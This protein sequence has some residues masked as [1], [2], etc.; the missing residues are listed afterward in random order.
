MTVVELK[1][2]V[3]SILD[4][5]ESDGKC[6]DRIGIRTQDVPFELGVIEHISHRWDDGC[7]TE[8][9]LPGLCVTDLFDPDERVVEEHLN[10]QYSAAGGYTAI[11][12]GD[13]V[14]Y[15][16]DLGELILNNA[17]VICIL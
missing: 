12:G 15:G 10:G 9:E 3:Q 1:E 5:L 6:F 14:E 17:E 4:E 7:D 16:E 8:E 2:K 13:F 11:V